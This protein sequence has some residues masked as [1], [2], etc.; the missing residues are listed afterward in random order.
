[1]KEVFCIDICNSTISIEN[2]SIPIPGAN[3]SGTRILS[4]QWPLMHEE[5]LQGSY[6]SSP[7][8]RLDGIVRQT[9]GAVFNT[10]HIDCAFTFSSDPKYQRP[11]L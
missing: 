9:V 6:L 7:G 2:R 10:G 11:A 1:M 5:T 8:I 4:F 3:L